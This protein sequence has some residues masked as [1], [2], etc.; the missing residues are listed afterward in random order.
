MDL[1]SISRQF[2]FTLNPIG[3]GTQAIRWNTSYV[4]SACVTSNGF[5]ATLRLTLIR[6]TCSGDARRRT[7]RHQVNFES[8]CRVGGSSFQSR[9]TGRGVGAPF[10]DRGRRHQRRRV[11]Q[12]PR[13]HLRA[14]T[15]ADS[16]VKA[17]MTI[18]PRVGVAAGA[19]VCSAKRARS[20]RAAVEPVDDDLGGAAISLNPAKLRDEQPVICGDAQPVEP[21]RGAS[22]SSCTGVIF[23]VGGQP[24]ARTRRCCGCGGMTRRRERSSMR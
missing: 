12:R 11:L 13:V 10:A 20:P 15:R 3:I 1:E 21:G 8:I 2:T 14:Q 6:S 16:A 19:A 23:R 17:G 7:P 24:A 22:I 18:S 5:G 9:R 4:L